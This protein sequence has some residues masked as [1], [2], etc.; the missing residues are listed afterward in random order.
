MEINENIGM[1]LHIYI[2]IYIMCRYLIMGISNLS[3]G[4]L[5]TEVIIYNGNIMGICWKHDRNIKIKQCISYTIYD[6]V[7][8]ECM[9]EYVC[10]HTYSYTYNLIYIYIYI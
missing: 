1:C 8:W 7:Y 4:M 5:P 6:N 3:Y 10:I 2:Y 9:Y